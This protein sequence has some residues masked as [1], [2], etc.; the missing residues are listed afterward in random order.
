MIVDFSIPPWLHHQ[1]RRRPVGSMSRSVGVRLSPSLE[2]T[3]RHEHVS[4]RTCSFPRKI[5]KSLT[6]TGWLPTHTKITFS[7]RVFG[8][9]MVMTLRCSA[10]CR[11]HILLGQCSG[12][13]RP[14]ALTCCCRAPAGAPHVSNDGDAM[15]A[16]ELRFNLPSFIPFWLHAAGTQPAKLSGGVRQIT[17]AH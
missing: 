14:H 2:S 6:L 5:S 4:R 13:V 17:P 9:K 1:R 15:M 3:V 16:A 10:A 7:G 11:P 12:M 8:N